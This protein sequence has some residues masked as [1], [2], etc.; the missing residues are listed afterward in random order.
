MHSWHIKHHNIVQFFKKAKPNNFSILFYSNKRRKH[1]VSSL[2]QILKI[3]LLKN[4]P[5]DL[6][7]ERKNKTKK[8][9]NFNI[10]VSISLRIINNSER[11]NIYA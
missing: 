8:K 1:F 5:K 4:I 9:R 7:F 11:K 6:N 10:F 2:T 3:P